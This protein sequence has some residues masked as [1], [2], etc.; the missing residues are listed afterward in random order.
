MQLERFIRT[1]ADFPQPGVLF[2]DL[3][4]LLGDACATREAIRRLVEPFRGLAA[5][6]RLRAAAQAGQAAGGRRARHL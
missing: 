1:V 6:C 4:P 5:R 2:R 3:T